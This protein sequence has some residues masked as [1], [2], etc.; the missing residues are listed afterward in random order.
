MHMITFTVNDRIQQQP[1]S[2]V[3]C[4]ARPVRHLRP[5]LVVFNHMTMT[6]AGIV[7][8]STSLYQC[9]ELATDFV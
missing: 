3:T 9:Q 2:S 5:W 8:V 4:L 6:P 1:S 7:L